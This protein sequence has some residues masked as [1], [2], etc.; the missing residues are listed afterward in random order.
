MINRLS[1]ANQREYEESV[2]FLVN[3]IV[4]F[5]ASRIENLF[6]N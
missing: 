4:L 5:P 2:L 3:F 6:E 1:L